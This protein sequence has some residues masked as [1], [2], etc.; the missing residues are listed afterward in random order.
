[1]KKLALVFSG[2][3]IASS[4]L[5]TAC[6]GN[7]TTETT[8]APEATTAPATTPAPGA[9]T[10]PATTPAPQAT[11]SPEATSSPQ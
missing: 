10:A 9:T 4:C 2:L 7:T 5:L 11:S 1:M 8:P 6:G 3:A